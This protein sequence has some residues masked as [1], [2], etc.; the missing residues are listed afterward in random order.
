M[1]QTDPK[2]EAACH[3]VAETFYGRRGAWLY[4]AF[5]AVNTELFCNELPYPLII[6]TLTAH[7]RCLG[8]SRSEE[9]RPPQI[10][11]H[12]SVFGGTERLNPW[13]VPAAYRTH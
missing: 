13:N 1:F 7:G 6:L 4:Q 11:I 10:A 3:V 2:V 5:R 8:W 12:P 9:E